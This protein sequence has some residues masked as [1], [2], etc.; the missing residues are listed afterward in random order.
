ML[1]D[2]RAKGTDVGPMVNAGSVEKVEEYVTIGKAECDLRLGGV[3]LP[4]RGDAAVVR[5][6]RSKKGLALVFDQ[7]GQGWLVLGV[8]AEGRLL[9][10]SLGNNTLAVAITLLLTGFFLMFNR[11]KAITQVL[12]LLIALVA[13]LA[14]M[15]MT[16]IALDTQRID[17]KR[18]PTHFAA[19]TVIVHIA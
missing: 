11:R 9:K 6:E 14:E 10:Q 17:G 1:G 2:G 3:L 7:T 12:A 13:V 19:K 16:G 18:R 5:V 4:G 8:K 15:E